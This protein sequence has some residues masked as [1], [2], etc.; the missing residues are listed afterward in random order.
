MLVKQCCHTLF[1]WQD[2][3]LASAMKA[4][5]MLLLNEIS[6]ADDSVLEQLNSVLE[7]HRL[8]VLAEKSAAQVEQLYADDGFQ[9]LATMNLGGDYGKRE[10]SPAL[11]NR[12]TEIWV[13][14]VTGHDDLRAILRH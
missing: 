12:F 13:P 1:E 4:G 8:L 6:L 11:R 14:T 9:L 5:D 3:P 2:G 10:L 7:P